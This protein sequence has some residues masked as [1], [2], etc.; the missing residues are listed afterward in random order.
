M[1]TGRDVAESHRE[2][3]ASERRG[4]AADLPGRR[5]GTAAGSEV[6]QYHREENTGKD[7]S[8]EEQLRDACRA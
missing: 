6:V 4:R 7:A 1:Q 5:G 8:T 3:A 2:A